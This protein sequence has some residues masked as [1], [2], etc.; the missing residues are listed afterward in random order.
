MGGGRWYYRVSGHTENKYETVYDENG[1]P[2]VATVG[3]VTG[4]LIKEKKD[5]TG[6]HTSLPSYARTSDLYFRKGPTGKVV[7]ASL[8]L[9]G[10]KVL[11]FD[12][13]HKHIN[14]LGDGKTFPNGI[15]HVQFH[16]GIGGKN[17]D[18]GRSLKNARYMTKAEIA[19]YGPILKY[20]CPDIDFGP[21]A[22]K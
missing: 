19:K 1:N 14:S 8:Y 7:Q 16:E 5:P 13:G 12:W 18:R 10:K 3:G 21:N 15:V 2:L 9:C 4:C 20:F 22:K 11:D 17:L 6:T